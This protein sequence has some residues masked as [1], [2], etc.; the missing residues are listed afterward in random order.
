MT[1]NGHCLETLNM[2][3]GVPQGSVLGPL[4]FLICINDFPNA[5]K[6]LKFRLFA[7]Y[8]H[9]FYSSSCSEE[10]QTTVNKELKKVSK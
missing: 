5:S 6:T 9:I 8:T 2:T 1:V 3:C 4:L 10:L 7:D